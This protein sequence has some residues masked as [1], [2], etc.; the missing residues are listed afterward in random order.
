MQQTLSNYFILLKV[1]F[2]NDAY[3]CTCIKILAIYNFIFI[4]FQL[5]KFSYESQLLKWC[6]LQKYFYLSFIFNLKI[7]LTK[8]FNLS[9]FWCMIYE[10]TLLIWLC[11][12]QL[13]LEISVRCREACSPFSDLF[14]VMH[15]LY[16]TTVLRM[17]QVR[18]SDHLMTAIYHSIQM[19]Q[20]PLQPL[21]HQVVIVVEMTHF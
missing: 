13:A 15:Y 12:C 14:L 19:C 18:D 21:L 2:S 9:I 3:F 11:N 4:H 20:P 16:Q 8:V 7:I 5:I 10:V 1:S 6:L 17:P